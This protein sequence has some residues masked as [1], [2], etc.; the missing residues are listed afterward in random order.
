LVVS[1][2]FDNRSEGFSDDSPRALELHNHRKDALHEALENDALGVTNWGDT[3]DVVAHE[4]AEIIAVVSSSPQL[5]AIAATAAT[6]V[7]LEL[8]KAGL[9]TLASEIVKAL[10]ARLIPQQQQK[11]ITEFEIRLPDG[12]VVQCDYKSEVTVHQPPPSRL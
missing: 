12:T 11:K 7:G 1:R 3:D 2:R 5:H 9:G 8:L 10:I 6:W 4:Y